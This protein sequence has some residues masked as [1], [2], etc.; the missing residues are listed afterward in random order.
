MVGCSGIQWDALGLLRH[1]A[2]PPAEAIDE[3]GPGAT[4]ELRCRP[5]EGGNFTNARLPLSVDSP[6]R[7]GDRDN[8][9]NYG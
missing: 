5:A 9:S 6:C 7:T 4:E 3:P 1:M 2:H 8:E